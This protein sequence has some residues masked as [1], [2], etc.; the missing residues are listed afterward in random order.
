MNAPLGEPHPQEVQASQQLACVPTQAEPPPL[1]GLHAA[2][3]AFTLHFVLVTLLTVFVWQQVTKPGLRHVECAAHLMTARRHGLGKLV[4][5][6][7]WWAT[8]LT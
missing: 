2:A 1:G 5:A 8:Q 3:V 6:F 7:T 4:L